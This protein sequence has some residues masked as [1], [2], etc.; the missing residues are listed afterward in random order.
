[1]HIQISDAACAT[2][3]P[4]FCKIDHRRQRHARGIAI[5]TDTGMWTCSDVCPTSR[6]SP[7]PD[8]TM[9][10][11]TPVTRRVA[12]CMWSCRAHRASDWPLETWS[13]TGRRCAREMR[14]NAHLCFLVGDGKITVLQ[15][16]WYDVP[17]Q[18][19]LL[20]MH[21]SLLLDTNRPLTM[22]DQQ[23]EVWD[24]GPLG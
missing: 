1:M 11:F 20:C 15:C 2:C 24:D 14:D 6:W 13:S 12:R 16:S 7:M 17:T 10:G 22:S 9:S 21:R 18:P 3:Q 19:H 4:S 23:Y 5:S 8:F